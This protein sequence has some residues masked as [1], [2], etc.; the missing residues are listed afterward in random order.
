MLIGIGPVLLWF[1]TGNY[2]MYKGKGFFELAGSEIIS[3]PS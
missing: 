1:Y 3:Y 2:D